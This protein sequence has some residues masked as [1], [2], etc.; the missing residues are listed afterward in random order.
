MYWKFQKT[1]LIS[2]NLFDPLLKRFLGYKASG[3]VR[4]NIQNSL[5]AQLDKNKPVIV[6][7][8]TDVMPSSQVPGYDEIRKHINS[9]VGHST[10]T[11]ETIK[12]MRE[13]C[14][15]ENCN[16]ISFEDENT[17]GLSGSRLGQEGMNTPFYAY[18]YG[19]GIHHDSE[20]QEDEDSRG[21][22]HGVGKIASNS[23]SKL[24][25]MFFAN[26]EEDGYQTLCGTIVL[27]DHI[28]ENTQYR[29]IGYFT[30]EKNEQYI[31]YEND[32]NN[33]IFNKNTRGLKIIIPFLRD[34]YNEEIELKRSVIDS[35]L[36]SILS[37]NL[38]VKVNGDEINKDNVTEY[39][40]SDLY[41]E[42]TIENIVDR[43]TPLYLKTFSSHYNTDNLYIYDKDNNYYRFKLY[44]WFDDTSTIKKGRTA[45][46]RTIGMKIEDKKI[47][48]Y[49]NTPYNAVLLPFSNKE[50]A[51]LK[52]LENESHTQLDSDH[53]DSVR[54]EENAKRFINNISKEIGNIIQ[55]HIDKMN[56]ESGFMDVKDALY[57][58]EN[59][60]ATSLKRN[61][62]SVMIGEGKKAKKL[63][64]VNRVKRKVDG[65]DESENTEHPKPDK[66]RKPSKVKREFGDDKKKEY[67]KMPNS[68]IKRAIYQ[69]KEKI[70]ID[71][72]GTSIIK[73]S[74]VGNIL[75]SLVDGRG[76]EHKNEFD[77]L[78]QYS[79]VEDLNSYKKL[80]L[81]RNSIQDVS[82]KNG[83]I[84]L[85]VN[86]NTNSS[87]NS[88][89]LYYLE[90]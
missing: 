86:H 58:L 42:Q 85:S 29:G 70:V 53:F 90:V 87:K 84:K 11:K 52:S 82:I 75:I 80:E 21:G 38:I 45:I 48:S 6:S 37:G 3:L 57:T 19:K 22:S 32:L 61:T 25:T 1:N 66:P 63:V 88:K 74:D 67:Y 64:K 17:K 24:H 4:E 73:K 50:D 83:Y 68:R 77:L 40:E 89:L 41:Y 15:Q 51:F 14:L 31:P 76:I 27:N 43:F 59:K 69:N 47:N 46:F 2:N 33:P 30:N 9:L 44:F 26:C 49:V 28:V 78:S 39:V 12:F 10:Y 23:A 81:K 72:N 62:T 7:I 56:P 55:R 65:D 16:Y 20:K 79:S 60:F 8:K 5:D 54:K 35:F 18:A 36:L 34:G 71:L 13:A